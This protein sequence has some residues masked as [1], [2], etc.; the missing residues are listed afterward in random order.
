MPPRSPK[1]FAIHRCRNRVH[2]T[3]LRQALLAAPAARLPVYSGA[4]VAQRAVASLARQP[5]W[6]SSR[7]KAHQSN[8]QSPSNSA[9]QIP[10]HRHS[11]KLRCMRQRDPLAH[12]H[13]EYIT[14][15]SMVR[16][17][18]GSRL[19]SVRAGGPRAILKQC[20]PNAPCCTVTTP[21]HPRPATA[22]QCQAAS[23]VQTAR[24]CISRRLRQSRIC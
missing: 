2:W 23:G 22:S 15:F 19:A 13:F 14:R 18:C 4:W 12:V 5:I 16:V 21:G 7:S 6:R 9:Q 11:P 1:F 8:E 17:H 3:K 20:P 24:P 10:C